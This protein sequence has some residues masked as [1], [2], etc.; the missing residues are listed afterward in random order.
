MD[1]SMSK[2]NNFKQY[3]TP[4]ELANY[5]VDIVPENSIKTV[6]DLSM[7]ECGLLEAAKRRWKDAVLF[8]A[9]IDKKLIQDITE[10]SPYINAYFGDSLSSDTNQWNEY[11]SVKN[12]GGFDLAI[13]NPPFDFFN[14]EL[15]SSIYKEKS[16]TLPIEM[17]F[18]LKYIEIVKNNGYIC[19]ILPY[20]FLSLDAYKNFRLKILEKVALLKVIKIF[21]RCFE[22]IDADTCLLLMKK[23]SENDDTVQEEISIEYLDEN[24]KLKDKL[25]VD[26]MNSPRWDLEYLQMQ[27]KYNE[28]NHNM[29]FKQVQFREL[30]ENCRRGKSITKNKEFLTNTG[31]RFIHT[32]DLKKLYISNKQ[33]QFVSNYGDFFATAK[34]NENEV[35]VGRVGRGCIGK[36][37]IVSKRYPRMVFSDCIYAITVKEINPYYL[38]LFLATNIAQIQMQGLAKGSCSKYL[39]R[40]ELFGIIILVPEKGVQDYFGDK[41]KK[42]LS[43]PGRS[44]K[45]KL[46]NELILKLE[47]AINGKG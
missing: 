44:G 42:I 24:Y 14:Q 10:K 26:T 31:T 20:G 8:G 43:K 38:T 2:K 36:V 11:C 35:L 47:E 9:D 13:A 28:L 27:T 22:K 39:T 16:I 32:T 34:L 3:F 5:M 25:L 30:I 1:K 29:N 46:L 6:V 17:R 18:L 45:E 33:K 12:N 21:K 37:G 40:K 15:I 23:K 4:T 41:Y 19:I 7:G